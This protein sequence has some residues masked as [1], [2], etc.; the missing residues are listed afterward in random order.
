MPS[1]NHTRGWVAL[2]EMRASQIARDELIRE[3]AEATRLDERD[4]ARALETMRQGDYD[5]YEINQFTD[6]IEAWALR[7]ARRDRREK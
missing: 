1:N 3:I 4:V 6:V 2:A 7:R 5:N